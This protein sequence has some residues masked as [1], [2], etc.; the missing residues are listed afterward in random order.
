MKTN[1]VYGNCLFGAIYVLLKKRKKIK[2]IICL[3]SHSKIIPFHI[4][5]QFKTG[6]IIHFQYDQPSFPLW[7]KG[8]YHFIK[9][10]NIEKV[11]KKSNRSI[12]YTIEL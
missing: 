10:S 6:H 4:V 11:F 5:L 7:F 12:L 8:H 1:S 9:K 3:S 2:R